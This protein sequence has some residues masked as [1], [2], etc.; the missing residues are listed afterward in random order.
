MLG[1]ARMVLGWVMIGIVLAG[2]ATT[3]IPA[4]FFHQWLGPSAAGLL[5]TLGLALIMEVCSVGTAPMAF[6]IWKQTGAFGNAFVFLMGGV[7]TDYTMVGLL[8]SNIGKKTALWMV[9]ISVPQVVL[10]GCIANKIF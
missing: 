1:L 6:Q 4:H 3:F 2:L 9:M 5:A 7:A 10:L 8:W